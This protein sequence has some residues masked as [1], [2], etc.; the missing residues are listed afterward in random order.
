M[1]RYMKYKF[2]AFFMSL[3]LMV[4]L[5]PTTLFAAELIPLEGKLKIKG[6]A[7]VGTELYANYGKVTPQGMT[8][9]QVTFLWMRSTLEAEEEA[10]LNQTENLTREEIGKEAAYTLTTEDVGY[11]VILQITGR[12]EWGLTGILEA[13]T[14]IITEVVEEEFV[15]EVMDASEQMD[16]VMEDAIVVEDEPI[17]E[18]L[19]N[20]TPAEEIYIEE[21]TTETT[22]DEETWEEAVVEEETFFEDSALEEAIVGEQIEEDIV[23]EEIESEDF[24]MEDS[25]TE[26]DLVLEEVIVEE[27]TF[28]SDG[29]EIA[30]APVYSLATN[31]GS[32]VIDF[33][34]FEQNEEGVGAEQ[35]LTITNDGTGDI[36]IDLLTSELVNFDIRQV[37]A[38]ASNV[39][40]PGSQME[41]VISMV[42]GSGM[43]PGYYSEAIALGEDGKAVVDLEAAFTVVESTVTEA[44][45]EP[46]EAP[47]ETP[48]E[49]TEAPTEA[50]A[51]PTEAPTEAPVEPTEVPT[52]APAE[53]TEAPTETPAEPTETPTETPAEPTET[54][55][56]A[57]EE[58]TPTPTEAPA[59]VTAIEVQPSSHNFG[60]VEVGYNSAPDAQYI[61][62][63]N[64]GNTTL[65]LV[66]PVSEYYV[67]GTLEKTVLEPN[68]TTSFTVRPKDGLKKGDYNETIYVETAEGVSEFVDLSF[69]VTAKTISLQGIEQPAN[70]TGLKNGVKKNA[71]AL[72]LPSTVTISTT[73]GDMKASVSWDV[74]SCEYS[75][76]SV[77][78][79]TFTV[80]GQVTLPDGIQNP[81]GIS[82]NVSV[83]VTVSAYTPK[84]ADASDNKIT[85]ISSEKYTTQS[86]I[87]FTAV[88][89]GM[90]NESPR[91]GDVRYCPVSWG[92]FNTNTWKGTNYSAA[93]G[94]GQAGTYN[95][96]VTFNRQQ[97]DGSD[98][99]NTGEQDKKTVTFEVVQ[100]EDGVNL[101]PAA[102]THDTNQKDAVATGD[103]TVI[104]PLIIAL[105]V[106]LACVIAV[107]VYRKKR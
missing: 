88:G 104:L 36:T 63:V 75:R 89:A 64:T 37:D 82:L 73:N 14:D 87:T 46:T 80:N 107:I 25:A 4:S 17:D 78:E 29:T 24:V 59:L 68:E 50:P 30:E 58:P 13:K 34:T 32:N 106:A 51:E 40:T 69:V 86:K 61:T 42:Y 77:K 97:Y 10:E 41:Y 44:P 16:V 99:V 52:E 2:L 28:N 98:W 27:K 70:I 6:D 90:D 54:P 47:T 66:Q 39:L 83:K 84:V 20:E 95:L 72:Q 12:E 19:I 57:P 21:E 56:E 15:E 7:V 33:G 22:A 79:Q 71:S 43:E 38:D 53:P 26:D 102:E 93:F 65:N 23:T 85:G 45:A 48:V 92:V 81:N 5:I 91:K 18:V 105:I 1:K 49:P 55:T 60:A 76:K 9:E 100:A 8:D 35:V 94:M 11:I 96:S 62:I 74:D 101:T 31:L 3:M 103:T 67:I